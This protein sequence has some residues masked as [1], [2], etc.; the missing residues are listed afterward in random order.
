MHYAPWNVA[1]NIADINQCFSSNFWTS[2]KRPINYKESFKNML[3]MSELQNKQQ[4]N[5]TSIG[6]LA[7]VVLHLVHYPLH[8]KSRKQL[9]Q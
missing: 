4:L 1:L 9:Q 7:F 3:L 2:W 5:L 8:N 6:V